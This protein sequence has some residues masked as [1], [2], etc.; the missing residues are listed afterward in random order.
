[1]TARIAAPNTHALYDPAWARAVVD[2]HYRRQFELYFDIVRYAADLA[3]RA[4]ASAPGSIPHHMVLSVLFRQAIAASDAVGVLL[5]E[6]AVDQGH[7]QM[8]ALVEARWGLHLALRDPEKWGRHI[9]VASL[10]EQRFRAKRWISGTPEYEAN[11]YERELRTNYG[12]ADSIS[13]AGE[14]GPD[15]RFKN[16]IICP[17][18][19]RPLLASASRGKLGRYYGAYHCARSHARY[20]VS[21]RV[22]EPAVETFLSG[23][24]LTKVFTAGLERVVV[25]AFR[26]ARHANMELA[27]KASQTVRELEAERTSIVDAFARATSD[28]MRSELERKLA[29]VEERVTAA[30]GVTLRARYL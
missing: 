10:R 26:D 18:C 28:A 12:N 27:A 9:Y 23:L 8:R 1:M 14:L 29:S 22:L 24:R 7:L 5:K 2:Q 13:Q 3:L 16:I 25:A 6:G 11:L 30:K 20:A 21:Q 15:Y 17:V 19:R 4:L